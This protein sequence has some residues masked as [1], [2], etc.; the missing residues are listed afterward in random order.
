[1]KNA[2]PQTQIIAHPLANSELPEH[3][4][5]QFNKQERT[6]MIMRARDTIQSK[7]L[8]SR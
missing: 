7:S 5:Q 3:K 1:M 6:G 8:K 2:I 4:K